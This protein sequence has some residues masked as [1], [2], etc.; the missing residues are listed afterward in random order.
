[1][2][3][4][5]KTTKEKAKT[6]KATKTAKATKTTK[7]KK[8]V[9][10]TKVTKESKTKKKAKATKTK[11]AKITETVKTTKAART[12]KPKKAVK[13]VK[14][15]IKRIRYWEGVGRRKTAVARVRIFT[16]GE[17]EFLVNEKKL[18]NYFSVSFLD[19]KAISPL[20]LLKLLDKF[21]ITVKVRG[22]GVDA[23]AEAIRHGL[24]RALI[25]FNP[26]FRKKLKKAGF[27]TRDSRMKERKKFGLKR[28]R[29]APQWQKR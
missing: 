25:K 6:T 28:A 9:K 4:T 27:L 3:T 15:T 16:R 19:E 20:K 7:A 21:R 2:D 11:V 18:S 10:A 14:R 26:N 17:K 22:G 24:S 5:K 12:V 13:A 8:A 29:R 23:Q 1:M